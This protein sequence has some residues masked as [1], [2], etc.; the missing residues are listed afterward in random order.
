MNLQSFRAKVSLDVENPRILSR[1]L[2]FL[3]LVKQN[4]EARKIH[5][6]LDDRLHLLAMQHVQFVDGLQKIIQ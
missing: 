1:I 2:L 5:V 3:S 6:A 4:V